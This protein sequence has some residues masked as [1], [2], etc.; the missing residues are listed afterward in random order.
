MPS[1][2]S[3][4]RRSARR[5]AQRVRADRDHAHARREEAIEAALTDYLEATARIDRA[6]EAAHLRASRIITTADDAVAED[7]QAARDAVRRLHALLGIAEIA[8]LCDLTQRAVRDMVADTEAD[9][10]GDG[11]HEPPRPAG[12]G[13][14]GGEQ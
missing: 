13:D 11:P 8:V 3:A 2:E 7:K 14:D 4:T 9:T 12:E 10:P 6:M 5:K 1:R